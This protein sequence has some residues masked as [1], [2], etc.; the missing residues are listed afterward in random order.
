MSFIADHT[1]FNIQYIC[2]S[3]K[4]DEKWHKI[5][6]HNLKIE[7]FNIKTEMKNLKTELKFFNLELKLIINFIWLFKSENQ[8]WNKHELMILAFKIEAEA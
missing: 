2:V 8:S 1:L 3:F 6:I 5:V 4:K 7:I